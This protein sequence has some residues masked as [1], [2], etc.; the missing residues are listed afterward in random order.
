MKQTLNGLTLRATILALVFILA[1]VTPGLLP[2][3]GV[4]FAQDPVAPVL[5]GRALPDGSKVDLSWTETSGATS[6]NLWRDDGTGYGTSPL[7]SGLTVRTYEDT[8][9]V[10]GQTYAYVVVPL[11][12]AD[13]PLWSNQLEL[14]IPGTSQTPAKPG[15]PQNLAA[16]VS[17]SS[18]VLTWDAVATATGYNLLRYNDVIEDWDTIVDNQNVLTHTDS[19]N[20][21]P[22]KKYWYI[23]SA[24]NAGGEGDFSDY[25][26]AT[27]PTVSAVPVLSL[28]HPARTRVE[29]SWTPVAGTSVEYDLQRR[30]QIVGDGTSDAAGTYERLPANLLSGTTHVDSDAVFDTDD[31]SATDV[32]ADVTSIVYH[33]R[34]QAVVD[35]VQGAWS[36]VKTATVP[37]TANLPGTPSGL[38]A[39]ASGTDSINLSWTAGTPDIATTYRFQWKS[40]TQDWSSSREG[41]VSA[42]AI[43]HTHT[44]RSPGTA[45]TYRVRGENVNGNSDWSNEDSATT[46]SAITAEGRLAT[47]T[48][49]SVTD[50]TDSGGPKLKVTWSGVQGE[51]IAY[52]VM[53]WG[54]AP[55]AWA[56][57]DFVEND[58]VTGQ[59]TTKM[60]SY[61]DD[62]PTGTGLAAGTSYAYVVRAVMTN[63]DGT[64]ATEWSEWTADEAGTTK[65]NLPGQPTLVAEQRG[66]TSVWLSWT[67]AATTADPPVGAATGYKLRYR[68]L[69]TST[70]TNL[71]VTAG[72]MTHVHMRLTPGR[73]YHYQVA[74]ENSA[75]MGPWSAEMAATTTMSQKPAKPTNV[76]VEDAS[77][78]ADDGTVTTTQVKISWNAVTGA[79]GYEI[80]R[81]LTTT[82]PPAWGSTGVTA[83]EGTP[84]AGEV[85]EVSGGSTTEFNDDS[86]GL[87][88]NTTY[89]YIVRAVTATAKG[90]WTDYESGTTKLAR[91]AGPTLVAQSR[92]QTMVQLSWF[93]VPN[94]TS[95]QL[96]FIPRRDKPAAPRDSDY[97]SIPL[98][99]ANVMHYTH[100]GLTAGTRYEYSVRAILPN[101]VMTVWG[102]DATAATVAEVTTRPL[103]P[104]GFMADASDHENVE[105]TWNSVS[106]DADGTSA[107]SVLVST[108]S[109]EVQVRS[110]G[111]E[112][113]A[114]SLT[115]ACTGTPATCSVDH[116][117][118]VPFGVGA[119]ENT[120]Y[121]YRLRAI[122][123]AG[124][125][126]TYSYWVYANETTPDDPTTN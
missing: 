36:N 64:T 106:F 66:D 92:G 120:Q 48:G 18:I 44:G 39:A 121:F 22:G 101:G 100:T 81:W 99:P 45:Y 78:I 97:T 114:I 25:G 77:V 112:W 16:S 3:D 113:T 62:G 116:T 12:A 57:V 47:P 8:S 119:A 104:T 32:P 102:A 95:Y 89:H 117:V 9:V 61:T 60:T 43:T 31:D 67:P 23:V 21:T 80:Q 55:T 59:Y 6:Y 122:G 75:G 10:A 35:G 53:R 4:A 103:R 69:P 19:N 24:Q 38:T 29:L 49:L 84:T 56:A 17:G 73:T 42:P 79:S 58:G 68:Q 7:A 91:P 110:S 14:T 5:S 109:Y 115:D 20:L 63:A 51:N 54:P 111:G 30:R 2:H 108:A 85:S 37:A 52:E 28:S 46:D 123:T 82:T 65:A 33:Y 15:I 50:A 1:A 118:S 126:L 72:A 71:P 83:D 105:L 124:Q 87:A 96:R 41:T 40:G 98:N 13:P 93:A 27:V 70:W 26:T 88:E 11:P 34:V 86:S 125:A 90:D 94:A 74:G 107:S 76:M